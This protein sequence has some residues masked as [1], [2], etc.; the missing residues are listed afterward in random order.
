MKKQFIPV[1]VLCGAAALGAIS[2]SYHVITTGFSPR[3]MRS[4]RDNNGIIV[5]SGPET[6]LAEE[7]SKTKKTSSPKN[8]SISSTTLEKN[9]HVS[10]NASFLYWQAQEEGLDFGITVPNHALTLP[11]FPNDGGKIV[12]FDSHYKPGFKASASINSYHDSWALIAAYTWFHSTVEKS[13]SAPSNG[14]IH[15]TWLTSSNDDPV[16]DQKAKWDLHLSFLDLQLM[17]PYNI[18]TCLSLKPNIGVRL[19]WI[20]QHFR[21]H[22]TLDDLSPLTVKNRSD[23]LGIGPI[24]GL[25]TDWLLGCGMRFIGNIN[26]AILYTHYRTRLQENTH[27]NT[28]GLN[29]TN[30]VHYL[31]P[32]VETALGLGWGTYYSQDRYYFDLSASYN[33]NV[34]WNQNMMRW[35]KDVENQQTNGGVGNLY[36]QGL[37]ATARF[38]F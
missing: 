24:L 30:N 22:H 38:D 23:S 31:R 13:Q 6:F 35:A 37:T 12:N 7:M 33:F 19:G 28:V 20:N 14:Y 16:L 32:A 21:V 4:C 36:L 18:T 10:L 2:I 8:S 17:R 15:S 9:W 11:A 26:G 29:L 25:N 27:Q 5:A 34:Y 3:Q 1:T